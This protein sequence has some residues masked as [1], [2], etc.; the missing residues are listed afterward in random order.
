MARGGV[1]NMRPIIA[2]RPYR[3][4]NAEGSKELAATAADASIFFSPKLRSRRLKKNEI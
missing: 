4:G 1:A 3:P 2:H